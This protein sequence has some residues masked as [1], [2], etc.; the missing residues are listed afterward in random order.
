MWPPAAKSSKGCSAPPRAG[1][2]EMRQRHRKS[3]IDRLPA[4]LRE[5]IG[6]LRQGGRTIEEIRAKLE[7]LNVRVSKS[8]LARHTQQLDVIGEQIRRS[9]WVGE[10]LIE[11]LGDAPE[12]RQAR[13][14]I[15]IMHS[16]ILDLLAG[17]DG[18]P[19]HL[20]PQSAMLLSDALAKLARAHQADAERELKLR[21]A[22][23]KETAGKVEDLARSEGLT[24]ETVDKFR[25]AILGIAA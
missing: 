10:A 11:R 14:N 9:R 8:A 25:A 24:A 2:S 7:E 5:L 3:S 1:E 6:Q 23:A 12:S 4:G 19:V 16:L 18:E 13:L 21:Q 15:E 17:E 22:I 20:T